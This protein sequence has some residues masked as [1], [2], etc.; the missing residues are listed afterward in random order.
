MRISDRIELRAL[1]LLSSLFPEYQNL[2]K[3]DKPDLVDFER[4]I[5]VEVTDAVSKDIMQGESYYQKHLKNEEFESCSKESIK[6]LKKVGLKPT[7]Q[8]SEN[9]IRFGKPIGLLRVFGIEELDLLHEAIKNKYSKKYKDLRSLDLYIL[10]SQMCLSSINDREFEKLLCTAHECEKTY[11]IV[12]QKI[13][14]DFIGDIEIL[15]LKNDK[16]TSLHYDR[17]NFSKLYE[18]RVM[19]IENGEKERE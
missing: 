19:E 14:I 13:M 18:E 9:G 5:G 2:Q 6:K 7:Y 16:I 17:D 4:S 15:N 8:K 10:F 11:G 1:M 3:N 12:F